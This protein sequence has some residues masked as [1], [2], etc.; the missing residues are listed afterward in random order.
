[1]NTCGEIATATLFNGGFF[2]FAVYRA[3]KDVH[4]LRVS[5]AVGV[6]MAAVTLV[7]AGAVYLVRQSFGMDGPNKDSRAKTLCRVSTYI[8]AAPALLGSIA[9]VC[10]AIWSLGGKASL[11][12]ATVNYA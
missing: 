11:T 6:G 5:I 10:V 3:V 7:A 4:Y 9:I 1:M 8:V 2:G 12:L